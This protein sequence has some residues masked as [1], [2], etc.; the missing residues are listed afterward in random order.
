MS[1]SSILSS[2]LENS[3]FPNSHEHKKDLQLYLQ[4][5]PVILLLPERFDGYYDFVC[6]QLQSHVY[7]SIL[8]PNIL[9]NLH[10]PSADDSICERFYQYFFPLLSEFAF[11]QAMLFLPHI[12]AQWDDEENPFFARVAHAPDHKNHSN[13]CSRLAL[14]RLQIAQKLSQIIL[15]LNGANTPLLRQNKNIFIT[16]QRIADAEDSVVF[17]EKYYN[18]PHMILLRQYLEIVPP[19]VIK[20]NWRYQFTLGLMALYS[21]N[22]NAAF[23]YFQIV[24]ELNER[25]K[26]ENFADFTSYINGSDASKNRYYKYASTFLRFP[27]FEHYF[28]HDLLAYE[29]VQS[30]SFAINRSRCF[31]CFSVEKNELDRV[32]SAKDRANNQLITD[33][34]QND[35]QKFL[36]HPLIKD[37]WQ[38]G[39]I[40]IPPHFFTKIFLPQDQNIVLKHLFNEYQALNKCLPTLI[41]CCRQGLAV[42]D[43][44]Y[45]LRKRMVKSAQHFVRA[46]VDDKANTHND[47][48]FYSLLDYNY[49]LEDKDYVYSGSKLRRYTTSRIMWELLQ[50][51]VSLEIIDNE[52]YL[53]EMPLLA[54]DDVK[55]SYKYLEQDFTYRYHRAQQNITSQWRMSW[56]IQAPKYTSISV[57]VSNSAA[58]TIA[59]NNTT[60]AVEIDEVDKTLA[61]YASSYPRELTFYLSHY[62]EKQAEAMLYVPDVSL[63]LK[64]TYDHAPL[65]GMQVNLNAYRDNIDYEVSPWIYSYVQHHLPKMVQQQIQNYE[66][67]SKDEPSKSVLSVAKKK[68]SRDSNANEDSR[69][70][71]A[72]SLV[73]LQIDL[74]NPL[75]TLL[76]RNYD[77]CVMFF[78]PL[79]R[80]AHVQA[81]NAGEL[82]EYQTIPFT[83]IYLQGYHHGELFAAESVATP[84]CLTIAQKQNMGI[85]SLALRY[86]ILV[87]PDNH[88]YCDRDFCHY[89]LNAAL[90]NSWMERHFGY[91]HVFANLGKKFEEY[92]QVCQDI[93]AC[94]KFALCEIEKRQLQ[95]KSKS[96]SAIAELKRKL[97]EIKDDKDALNN[98]VEVKSQL[99]KILPV[100]GKIMQID[101]ENIEEE[102]KYQ[103]ALC[104]EFAWD[105]PFFIKVK[106]LHLLKTLPSWQRF[107]GYYDHTHLYYNYSLRGL[108]WPKPESM[109]ESKLRKRV[110]VDKYDKDYSSGTSKIINVKD[111][112]LLPDLKNALDIDHYQDM[113]VTYPWREDVYFGRTACY[114]LLAAYHQGN[115]TFENLNLKFFSINFRSY[116]LDNLSRLMQLQAFAGFIMV[117]VM[118]LEQSFA[119]GSQV[120]G[121]VARVANDPSITIN[122]E[123]LASLIIDP[124]FY[125][126]AQKVWEQRQVE[127]TANEH[128]EGTATIASTMLKE[129]KSKK[130]KSSKHGQS[131]IP[132][133][134]DVCRIAYY[135]SFLQDLK[136]I[137][138]QKLNTEIDVIGYALGSKYVYL[139]LIIWDWELFLAKAMPLKQSELA[140]RYGIKDFT[141]HS[142][143]RTCDELLL[144]PLR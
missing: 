134:I 10:L 80:N 89:L 48:Y 3:T 26:L 21:K 125:G 84:D 2:H 14:P 9:D 122:P 28:V 103:Q 56:A 102:I 114:R 79:S 112:L 55:N 116:P 50:L 35:L 105:Q 38:A 60:A 101:H 17:A 96:N 59:T 108:Q 8:L 13:F 23:K 82:P 19:Q 123:F 39:R 120:S 52:M 62:V 85:G 22:Y 76:H 64:Q 93:T 25:Y 72:R 44:T 31:D 16:S 74:N 115:R 45:S 104:G 130:V 143:A 113:C 61:V 78:F 66:Q 41:T 37:W 47:D 94:P 127:L 118:Q 33:L 5:Y 95:S 73:K 12:L 75:P 106:D 57:L 110:I 11:T 77:E 137:L 126:L 131:G 135:L 24:Q 46:Q 20:G 58:A 49:S 69:A 87:Y 140:Q 34:L 107:F 142:F 139:D 36:S 43:F 133:N 7:D 124:S 40:E 144:T 91:M 81:L 53:S 90:G 29:T 141:F 129:S 54:P 6:A 63:F 100:N 128:I 132:T 86:R 92:K 117:P 70:S 98:G 32:V 88:S 109:P 15:K 65:K 18:Y 68:V 30:A 111:W 97:K 71:K 42:P 138:K 121:K 4:L 27:L 67:S 136:R 99:N 51:P 83:P 119:Q 1:K